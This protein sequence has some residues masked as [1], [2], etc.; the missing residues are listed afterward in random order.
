MLVG[1]PPAAAPVAQEQR[2]PHPDVPRLAALA[3]VQALEAGDEG[4][5][6]HDLDAEVM[7][8]AADRAV[9]ARHPGGDAL[10]VE[11]VGQRWREVEDQRVGGV[12]REER[13]RV[14]VVQRTGAG[15][16]EGL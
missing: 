16:E 12:G 10:G 3:A 8:L 15:D 11:A 5:V 14:A 13:G 4:Q 7:R 2:Q 9:P 6:A 1:D